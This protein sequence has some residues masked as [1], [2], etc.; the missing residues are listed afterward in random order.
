[1]LVFIEVV[2]EAGDHGT[3]NA[4][5]AAEGN[6]PSPTFKVLFDGCHHIILAFGA[7]EGD[8]LGI[9]YFQ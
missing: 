8:W 3:D 1:M 4:S 9:N 2:H 7:L 5:T 6:K